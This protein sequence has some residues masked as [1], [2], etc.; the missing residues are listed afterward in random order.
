MDAFNKVYKHAFSS[1]SVVEVTSTTHM[2]QSIPHVPFKCD[3]LDGRDGLDNWVALGHIKT[4]WR[5]NP[6]K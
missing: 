1:S 2:H 3:M 4:S 6:F 5:R